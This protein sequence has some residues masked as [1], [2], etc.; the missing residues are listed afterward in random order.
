MPQVIFN[1]S[2]KRQLFLSS[3][4]YRVLDAIFNFSLLILFLILRL[5]GGGGEGLTKFQDGHELAE[6]GLELLNI[7]RLFPQVL[8]LQVCVFTPDSY[9]VSQLLYGR[10]L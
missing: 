6:A 3:E 4:E 1:I 10:L 7:F 5:G 8:V 9:L 2:Y